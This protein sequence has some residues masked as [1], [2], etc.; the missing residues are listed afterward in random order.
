MKK[1]LL[2]FMT[3]PYM[4]FSQFTATFSV[5]NETC[6]G[7]GE[8]NITIDN[9]TVGS[10]FSYY[11]Y[12]K[13][14][15]T[16]PVRVVSNVPATGATFDIPITSL[17]HGDYRIQIMDGTITRFLDP[18]TIADDRLTVD[19]IIP[20]RYISC[21]DLG[22]ELYT[23]MQIT[24]PGAAVSYE[25]RDMAGN[26]IRPWQASNKFPNLP[27]GDYRVAVQSSCGEV[28]VKDIL[29]FKQLVISFSPELSIGAGL[30]SCNVLSDSYLYIVFTVDGVTV[31]L[32]D[33]RYAA[34]FP[35]TLTLNVSGGASYSETYTLEPGAGNSAGYS[36]PHVNIPFTIEEGADRATLNFEATVQAACPG[37]EQTV[38]KT[39]IVAPSFVLSNFTIENACGELIRGLR[40]TS[41]SFIDF[42]GPTTVTFTEY[43]AG[44]SPWEHNDN[45]ST[46]SYSFTLPSGRPG[47]MDFGTMESLPPDG[48]YTVEIENCGRKITR[49]FNYVS[50]GTSTYNPR[51]DVRVINYCK[52]ESP[53]KVQSVQ[54]VP[55]LNKLLSKVVI[56]SAPAEF[57]AQYGALPYDASSLIDSE[58][59][60]WEMSDLPVGDYMFALSNT[61]C[62][63]IVFNRNIQVVE[64]DYDL[65][66]T[67]TPY[68]ST[69]DISVEL[70]NNTKLPRAGNPQGLYYTKG[71]LYFYLQKINPD[72]SFYST[73]LGNSGTALTSG[74][75]ASTFTYSNLALDKG[76]YRII[77]TS[78]TL[79]T[80][81]CIEIIDTFTVG[82]KIELKDYYVVYCGSDSYNLIIDAVGS[83]LTYHIT[84]RNGVPYDVDN[85]DNPIFTGLTEGKYTVEIRDLCGNIR[86]LIIE[87][88][89]VD[90]APVIVP[91]LCDGEEGQLSVDLP[92]LP[93]LEVEWTKDNDPTVIATGT[94]LPF[95]PF[96]D[97]TD[98]GV[99]HAR[100]YY[101]A[102]Q[103][104]IDFVL[105]FDLSDGITTTAN[106]G[107]GETVEIDKNE[108]IVNLFDYITGDYDG[109]GTWEEISSPQSGEQL[110]G[111]SWNPEN[112]ADGT[113]EF[114]YTVSAIC[115]GT[116]DETIVTIKLSGACYSPPAVSGIVLETKV[117]ITSLNRAGIKG[118]SWP[119]VRNG[120]WLA[121]ESKTKGFVVNRVG[122]DNVT[123]DP[124][125]IPTSAF[126]LG[127]LVYDT[128]NKCLKMYTTKEGE[129]TPAWHCMSAP[130][131]P[132]V[133]Y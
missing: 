104:C 44:F 128:T 40:I 11:I 72:G 7:N 4:V 61:E 5:T 115:G 122:F 32:R 89:Q 27:D 16:N 93:G 111:S 39:H 31:P 65:G 52:G 119:M 110:V 131:C 90:R 99:Y 100:V 19:N 114:K 60:L 86:N 112:V 57:V 54:V 70:M 18:V 35:L 8:V 24:A 48:L 26:V 117:G 68:C 82:D 74:T 126:E 3:I 103:S 116:T 56:T 91:N 15:I 58:G 59:E 14:D 25:L 123:G 129:T 76:E 45:F 113:Y 102:A 80:A 41:L 47:M 28:F 22:T 105:D 43:P 21:P 1:L 29:N 55:L 78:G 124:I 30:E 106:A 10:T 109:W 133:G 73:L 125:G 87:V 101:T 118:D 88:N 51:Y 107:T 9:A 17:G 49:S 42:T 67:V 69:T 120:G 92:N 71:T 37:F 6:S 81:N 75:G 97:A 34:L 20:D 132:I 77:A 79:A 98:R 130:G 96:N 53:G 62:P 23:G 83:N 85:E 94:V 64:L 121:L 108:G 46:G 66:A 127:M 2:L 84:S 63:H 13:P 50:H 36:T 95:S 33:P 12:K 38:T